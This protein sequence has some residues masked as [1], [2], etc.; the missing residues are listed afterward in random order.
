MSAE[1]G[2][3][4]I[5]SSLQDQLNTQNQQISSFYNT[6]VE[7]KLRDDQSK[8]RNTQRN[9]LKESDQVTAANMR[10][11]PLTSSI[12]DIPTSYYISMGALIATAFLLTAL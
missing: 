1:Q 8:I 6:D 2:I 12:P 3:Q 4:S 5:L 9:I 10:L 11:Q 7:G